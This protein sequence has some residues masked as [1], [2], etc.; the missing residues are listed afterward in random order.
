MKQLSLEPDDHM[1][2]IYDHRHPDYNTDRAKHLREAR[3]MAIHNAPEWM[4]REAEMN[5]TLRNLP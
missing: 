2:W 1:K 5:D 3:F 4:K